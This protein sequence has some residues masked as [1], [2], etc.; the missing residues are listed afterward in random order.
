MSRPSA[1]VVGELEIQL[2]AAE[3]LQLQLLELE[4][5]AAPLREFTM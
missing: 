4:I 5:E 3:I 2:I 1:F